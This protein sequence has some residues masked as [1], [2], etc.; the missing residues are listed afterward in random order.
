MKNETLITLTSVDKFYTKGAHTNH[1]YRDFC[2]VVKQGEFLAIMGPSG[3]GKTTLLNLITGLDIPDGGSIK[4]NGKRLD[5]MSN[6]E[7]SNW[8]S[9]QIGFVFQTSNLLPMLNCFRN[10]ELPLL[11]TNLSRHQRREQVELALELV[12][13][14]EQADQYPRELSGGQEQRCAIARAIVTNPTILVCDEPTGNLDRSLANEI[15]QLFSDLH[16]KMNKTIVLV[17][18]DSKAREFATRVID[19]E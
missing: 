14:S 2:A 3:C 13:L 4:V 9:E 16:R 11:L 10:T 8:R 7:L 5:M 12:S 19:L 18:H 17:S 6:R 15:L 1:V